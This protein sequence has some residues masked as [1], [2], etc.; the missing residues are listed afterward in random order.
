M[1]ILR[2]AKETLQY[3]FGKFPIVSL[4]GP[5]QSGKTTL[6]K[7]TFPQLAYV[8]LEDWVLQE[9]IKQDP[10]AFLAQYPDGLIID[11]A[12]YIPQ[13][14]HYIQILSD[15]R[16]IPGQYVLTGSQ[17]FLLYENITQSLA[18][19]VGIIRLL[20][21][22][23]REVQSVH[24][25]I[26]VN[27]CLF[28]GGYPRLHK[29]SIRPS[30]FFSGYLQTYVERDVRSLKNIDNLHLFQK[31]LL[32][33]AGRVGQVLNVSSLSRDV[34]VSGGTI[35]SWLSV[36]EASYVLYLLQPFALN[37]NKQMTKAPKLYFYDTGL[38]CYLL[39]IQ[40]AD[41][42]TQHY[43]YGSIFE[44]F[45]LNEILKHQLSHGEQQNVYFLRD[46]FGHE[47]D[48]VLKNGNR[49][50]L[51]EIKSSVAFTSDFVKNILYYKRDLDDGAVVYQGDQSITYK[52]VS[53]IPV[54]DFLKNFDLC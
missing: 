14:F 26:S 34:G 2:E 11:E 19:R 33:C 44:N 6:A 46:A 22:T 32:L 25:T 54:K 1:I 31:F 38:L 39:N 18:G 30:D 10:A 3:L 40:Q 9:K 24:N 7:Q 52:D 47:V 43:A 37:I 12:Q 42:V 8:N 21:L 27:D 45:V 28:Q 41:W 48:A 5:R 35:K 36:L 51:L 23:Y 49:K 20:P 50:K 4:T 16:N 17:D 53:V 13:L 29:E 15:E